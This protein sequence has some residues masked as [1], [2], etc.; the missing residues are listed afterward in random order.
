[1]IHRLLLLPVI[2]AVFFA[3]SCAFAATMRGTRAN[4]TGTNVSESTTQSAQKSDNSENQTTANAPVTAR[5]ANRD[6][7]RT[8]NTNNTTTARVA[9][10]VAAKA[11]GTSVDTN[12]SQARV[13][14]VQESQQS[15]AAVAARAATKQKAV[16]FGT[17]IKTKTENSGVPQDC[18][19][20]YFGC[21]DSFCMMDNTSGG[22]CR[23]DDRSA[24]L[25]KV[26]DE[27]INIDSKSKSLAEQGVAR[28][29]MGK[30]VDAV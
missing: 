20:A 3:D 29:K 5:A 18:H 24:E 6:R 13:R 28:L 27:L 1:M 30:D 8:T 15:S 23:C 21:M 10:R 26:L 2:A 17:K 11:P 14:Q 22:R 12:V 9:T 7:V 25:D 19:D 4:A 16:N